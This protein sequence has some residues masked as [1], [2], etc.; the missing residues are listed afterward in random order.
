MSEAEATERDV[1]GTENEL[2]ARAGGDRTM[3]SDFQS[4]HVPTGAEWREGQQ[5]GA[6]QDQP[7]ALVE[8]ST[9]RRFLPDGPVLV[10]PSQRRRAGVS[11]GGEGSG[12]NSDGGDPSSPPR[13]PWND[14]IRVPHA[15]GAEERSSLNLQQN[16][17]PGAWE[18]PK[19]WDDRTSS[20][21]AGPPVFDSEA[22][23]KRPPMWVADGYEQAIPTLPPSPQ[24]PSSGHEQHPTAL[25]NGKMSAQYPWGQNPALGGS[26]VGG[27]SP[28]EAQAT[29]AHGQGEWGSP[30]GLSDRA[31]EDVE[32]GQER[33][34]GG[35]SD[36]WLGGWSRDPHHVNQDTM[37][38]D[39]SGARNGRDEAG[40]EVVESLSGRASWTEPQY[41]RP[42]SG[43]HQPKQAS[44][45][46]EGSYD[47]PFPPPPHQASR[48]QASQAAGSAG[49]DS[50]T[51][52]SSTSW[53]VKEPSNQDP[54]QWRPAQP[55]HLPAGNH[56]GTG[57][58]RAGWSSSVQ[59]GM[60]EVGNAGGYGRSAR[61][62]VEG[63]HQQP[64]EF[65]GRDG[66][67]YYHQGRAPGRGAPAESPSNVREDENIV[68]PHVFGVS[69]IVGSAVAMCF[70]TLLPRR[71]LAGCL[72]GPVASNFLVW[73]FFLLLG[74]K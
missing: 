18:P 72:W 19:P 7:S 54:S 37:R 69:T 10:D 46:S 17:P 56:P 67:D 53:G 51:K 43:Y 41:D 62:E 50:E 36:P 38:A 74:G 35:V 34:S 57:E 28:V 13:D 55:R 6:C 12:G 66:G 59:G 48:F 73:I 31:V 58:G 40:F 33:G 71:S 60:S 22:E 5:A 32:P 14:Q 45:G 47:K 39:R 15:A 24:A 23:A 25:A 70:R 42:P 2:A 65:Y 11:I 21:P 8:P 20:V 68:P 16:Q 1:D 64:E 9:S 26:T 30:R 3:G 44:L 52:T 27:L 29:N 4:Q 49:S 61:L 63:R